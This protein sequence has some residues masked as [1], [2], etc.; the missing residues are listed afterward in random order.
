M[1]FIWISI[2]VF[3]IICEISVSSAFFC[4]CLAVGSI[5]AAA[6]NYLFNSIYIE[7]TV[8]IIVSVLSLC[9]VRPVFKKAVDRLGTVKT[10]ADSLIGACG[11]IIV[12]I[13]PL[14]PGF[15]KIFGELWRAESDVEILEGEKVRV[16]SL[17]GT[18]LTVRRESAK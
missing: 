12:K 7:I 3:L 6:V 5:A 10:N 1:W 15:V 17:N 18:T 13:T 11:I 14:N 2:A 9:F 4:I 16:E 8:F